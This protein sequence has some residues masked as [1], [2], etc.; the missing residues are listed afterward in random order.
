[1]TLDQFVKKVG[2]LDKSEIDKV[3]YLAF[4]NKQI[5]QLEEFGLDHVLE[6]FS[7]LN[8]GQPNTSRMR[9]RISESR[10]FVKGTKP[11]TYKL[12]AKS[13]SR[14]LEELPL[15]TNTSE[16]IVFSPSILPESLFEETRGYIERLAKQINA[17]YDHG[18]FDGCAVLMRRLLELSL[19]HA[20]EN[21][22]IKSQIVTATGD[23]VELKDMINNAQSNRTLS[24]SRGAKVCIDEFRRLGNFSAHKI[25][26]NCRRDDIK[27]IALDYRATIE[28]LFYKAGLRK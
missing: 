8:L 11:K 22:G 16:E 2:L 26:Y 7:T 27:N 12:H 4:F 5:E 28:E 18:L 20:Y 3:L 21:I 6:W 1:M 19:I 17:S 14:L 25:M 10:D 15:L 13:I 9:S 24:L 23:Y